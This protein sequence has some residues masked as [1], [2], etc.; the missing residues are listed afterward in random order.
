MKS[1][2][3][4][5]KIFIL[6]K[7]LF[8]LIPFGKMISLLDFN[9]PSAI[10][11]FNNN[12]FVV[13][14]NGIFVYDEQLQNIIYSHPFE[15]EN[16]KINNEDKLS[17]VIIKLFKDNYIICLINRKIFF[18]DKEGKNLL[19]K[20]EA[21]IT[22]SCYYYHPSLIP[23]PHLSENE[24]NIYYFVIAYFISCCGIVK[25]KLLL[26]KIDTNT[27][28]CSNTASS[29]V[30]KFDDKF[31]T[32][33]KK[34]FYIK[35][36]SCEYMHCDNTNKDYK[37]LVCFFIIE[38][39]GLTLSNNYFKV[40]QNSIDLSDEFRAAYRGINNV[41]QIQSVPRE[42]KTYSLV[43]LLFYDNNIK[44]YKFHFVRESWY[45]SD[46]VE[47]IPT[48]NINFN[49]KNVNYGLKLN[50]LTGDEIISLS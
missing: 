38:K 13:E 34:D 29:T 28:S 48:Q 14:K 21:L 41:V 1:S 4:G 32:S 11:L 9:Y 31:I 24:P 43:C 50:Y 10:S 3:N 44:C 5:I 16:D 27:K 18:F 17:K 23:L 49:C 46:I 39:D 12:V 47:F 26:Y 7:I 35:G 25:Q 2:F 20:T 8:L 30:D 33:R 42:D 37:Y 45:E 6:Y 22:E 36:L 15:D 19:L 40:T